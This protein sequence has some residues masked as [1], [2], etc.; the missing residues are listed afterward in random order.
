MTAVK[1]RANANDQANGKPKGALIGLDKRLLFVRSDHAALNTLLQSAGA[2]VMKK[3]LVLLDRSLQ[4]EHRLVPGDHYEFV[5]NCHDEFQIE[6]KPECSETVGRAAVRSI[7]DAG[8]YF[9]FR[10]PLDGQFQI[11]KTWADTH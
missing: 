6:A 10:C 2:L 9:N 8:T 11:G 3:A 4:R 7:R 1:A 5:V